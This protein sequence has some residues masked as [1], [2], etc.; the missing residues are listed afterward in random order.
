MYEKSYI[1]PRPPPKIS[2]RHDHDWT[3]GMMNWA[4]QLNNNLSVNSFNSLVEKFNMQRSPNQ[5]NQN[6]NHSVIDRGNLITQK[7]Y[8][9]CVCPFTILVGVLMEESNVIPMPSIY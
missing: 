9:A 1:S 5:P 3:R 6:P 2:L 7:M 8:D 4:L